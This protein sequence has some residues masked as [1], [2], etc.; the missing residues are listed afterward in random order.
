MPTEERKPEPGLYIKHSRACTLGKMISLGHLLII[1]NF[2]QAKYSA[3]AILKDQ[4]GAQLI[5]V[6]ITQHL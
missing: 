6:N 1:E 3:Q 5:C 2:F 4:N